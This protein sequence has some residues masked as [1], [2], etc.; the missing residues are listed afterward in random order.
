MFKRLVIAAALGVSA[1]ACSSE[2]L[3]QS[4]SACRVV[5]TCSGVTYTAGGNYACTMDTGGNVCTSASVSAS[6]TPMAPTTAATLSVSA[7]S[8][9]VALPS[10]TTTLLCNAGSQLAYYKFGAGAVTAAVT[11]NALFGGECLSLAPG[12]NTHLAGI[13]ASGTTTFNISGGAGLPTIGFIPGAAA[14][15]VNLSQI[16]GTAASVN[17]GVADAGT[18]RVTLA[19]NGT[20]VVAATQSGAWSVGLTGTLPAFA[21]TPAVNLSQIAGTAASVNNGAA[22]AGTLRVAPANNAPGVGTLTPAAAPSYFHASGG[23]YQ[24]TPPTLTDGQAHMLR[25]DASGNLYDNIREW[26]V[27]GATPVHYLSAASTNSTN[28]KASAGTV[29]S[30]TAINTTTTIYYLKMYNKA[31]AP[32]CGTDT[33]VHTLPVPAS[34]TAAGL[35]VNPFLGL[36][37]TAG[38]GFCLTGAIADADATAA[39]TGVAINIGY[40]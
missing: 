1:L 10:G 40:K 24:A 16:A 9:N 2:A 6:I 11:D 30:V 38:I 8:A 15:A 18:L 23:V 26:G 21:S 39:A 31:T 34:A 27:T 36:N 19:N 4:A 14:S 25:V 22:D 5:A 37:F 33:P 35:T 20:G 29:F 32:T 7:V 28:V 3:A 12:T 13:T 17:N